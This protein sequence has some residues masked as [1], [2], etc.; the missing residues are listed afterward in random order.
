MIYP[1]R[2]RIPYVSDPPAKRRCCGLESRE[3]GAL[4]ESQSSSFSSSSS[5]EFEQPGLE[6]YAS[7]NIDQNPVFGPVVKAHA[8]ASSE[9]PGLEGYASIH[10]K[11]VHVSG[12]SVKGH[13]KFSASSSTSGPP[14][15]EGFA[16]DLSE[17]ERPGPSVKGR[18]SNSACS[19]SAREKGV[20][21]VSHP[22]LIL[23]TPFPSVCRQSFS[24]SLDLTLSYTHC[25]LHSPIP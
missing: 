14:G 1:Q 18:A 3:G 13:A 19:R 11:P 17:F 9:K 4:A 8:S 20:R 12:P 23:L 15:L 10:Q 7:I 6:G 22:P 16:L 2:T 5:N 25:F 21:V 24:L